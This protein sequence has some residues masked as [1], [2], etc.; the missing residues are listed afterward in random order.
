[1]PPSL[2]VRIGAKINDFLREMGKV[3]GRLKSAGASMRTVGKGMTAG[4]TLP[5][6][7]GAAAVTKFS[8][9]LNKGMA[10][11][12][13]LIP[14]ST[15]R[16]VELKGAVQDMAV[17]MGKGTG[18]MATGLFDVISALGDT[19]ETTK[20]L[21]IN[22]RAA[23]AGLSE[24]SEAI[25]LTTAVTKGY[26]DT[27]AEA[28]QKVAD[29]AFK[30]NELGQTTFPE[31]AASIGRVVPL[32]AE[33]GISQE[34]LFG[35]MA[36]GTGVT[37]RAAEVST[38]FRGVLQ[39]LMVPTSDMR[40]LF[41]ELGVTSGKSMLAQF[42]LK[43]SL[44]KIVA[45]ARASGQP[46]QKYINQVEGQTLA[47]ALS[48]A[49]ADQFGQK[50]DAMGMAMGAADTAFKEQTEGVNAA[51]HEWDKFKVK[52][53]VAAEKMGDRLAPVLMEVLQNLQPLIGHVESAVQW[54]S[55]LSPKVQRLSI[56]G[57]G[58]VAAL[59][60]VVVVVGT[61]VGGLAALVGVIAAGGAG[62]TVILAFTALAGVVAA[63]GVGF[64]SVM[65]IVD[66]AKTGF[67]F[68]ANKLWGRAI[69]AIEVAGEATENLKI[70]QEALTARGIEP[71]TDALQAL[72][73]M[74]ARETASQ[75]D[76]A[77]AV[78]AT[79]GDFSTLTEEA[80]TL[81]DQ[82][83]DA[84]LAGEVATLESAWRALTPAQ[85]ENELVL[86]RV[87]EA[88]ETLTLR[89]GELSEEL[90]DIRANAFLA[91][92][93]GL[94]PLSDGLQ[95]V[96]TDTRNAKERMKELNLVLLTTGQGLIPL[97]KEVGD[98]SVVL[99][100]DVVPSI[101]DL[102]EALGD[103]PSLLSQFGSVLKSTL[104][105]LNNVFTS[106]FEGGGG[107]AGAIKSLTTTVVEGITAMIPVVG[108]V[109]SQFAGAIV[110]GFSKLGTAIMSIG[111]S[112]EDNIKITVERWGVVISDGL[113]EIIADTN[114]GGSFLDRLIG[115]SDGT[116]LSDIAAIMLN[117]G[118]IFD[119]AGGVMAFGLDKAI[120]KA[121]DLFVMLQ[122]GQ[123]TVQEVGGVFDEVF[124][125]LLP[126]SI[127]TATGLA[128]QD[129]LELIALAKEF[130]VVS[131]E[132]STFLVEQAESGA[133][134]LTTLIESGALNTEQG[135]Q[136]A[137]NA[138][139][140]FFNEATAV[141]NRTGSRW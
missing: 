57:V 70:Q 80:T 72:A 14:G 24:T 3:E 46:L 42:G 69:P 73:E 137:A 119:E 26:G 54:F 13:T 109:V 126:E 99:A 98:F 103:S 58:L 29:L 12:A 113:A 141:L 74:D 2:S 115:K 67:D 35:V 87:A 51:G 85:Q 90:V 52:I 75:R 31:L 89:G 114:R 122:T 50:I 133:A 21:E 81:R 131:A 38:Q 135:I 107:I 108:P 134:A 77:D 95:L 9:N 11:V 60:P 88:A 78:V 97:N 102:N 62:A 76:L 139:I 20:I 53:T 4:I 121:R 34:E 36:T 112:V 110:A 33:L 55:N 94:I 138:A 79:A 130:G 140:A 132:M 43:D 56:M 128:R 96:L 40:K 18:D 10:N 104:G 27:S 17:E 5:L 8:F 39:S 25:Q 123:L 22:A 48:G 111:R 105:D 32:S 45:A 129:F 16:V 83:S 6:V 41:G 92:Q 117:L 84:G 59:G 19:S 61:L 86:K 44:D 47:L 91:S 15:A 125:K 101:E 30:T 64:R 71:A 118:R 1:M 136:V 37:G 127:D 49:Q 124:G 106:A 63:L 93:A 23:V 82:L 66:I 100:D 116:G 120:A 65:Q 28:F 7:A 68:L